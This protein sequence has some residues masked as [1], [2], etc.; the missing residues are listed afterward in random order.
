M[1]VLATLCMYFCSASTINLECIVEVHTFLESHMSKVRTTPSEVTYDRHHKC[2]I[3]KTSCGILNPCEP[4]MPHEASKTR[5]SWPYQFD[6]LGILEMVS[7]SMERELEDGPYETKQLSG[8]RII[9]PT[10]EHTTK[11]FILQKQ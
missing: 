7:E 9:N 4:G 3:F 8:R 6:P 2:V 5:F 11:N 1:R 10:A